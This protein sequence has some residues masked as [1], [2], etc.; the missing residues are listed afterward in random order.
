MSLGYRY[1]RG[2]GVRK[3][4][5][6]ALLFYEYA[7]NYAAIDMEYKG[8]SI[9]VDK[10]NLGSG[11]MVYIILIIG[12]KVIHMNNYFF[13]LQAILGKDIVKLIVKL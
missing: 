2:L 12:N 8:Y 6:K 11:L 1:L 4:C 3:S 13:Y 7:A 10:S 9:F 5:V